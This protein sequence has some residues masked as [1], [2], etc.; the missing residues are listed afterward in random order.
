MASGG[1]ITDL[2]CSLFYVA[3]PPFIRTHSHA[4]VRDKLCGDECGV[5]T[6]TGLIARGIAFGNG[7][8]SYQGTTQENYWPCA[9]K[10]DENSMPL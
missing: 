3:F 7:G 10:V 4:P 2:L 8:A 6:M 1:A 9:R 5:E